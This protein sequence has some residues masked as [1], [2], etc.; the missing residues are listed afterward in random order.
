[1]VLGIGDDAGG[2]EGEGVGGGGGMHWSNGMDGSTKIMR[3]YQ[4]RG[5]VYYFGRIYSN[6]ATKCFLQARHAVK[7]CMSYI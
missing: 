4:P 1:M 7:W 3:R 5:R 2:G 6:S